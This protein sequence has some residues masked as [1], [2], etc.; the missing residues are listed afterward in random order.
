LPER[1]RQ[2]LQNAAVERFLPKYE[3]LIEAYYRRLAEDDSPL[4]PRATR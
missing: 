3:D 1:I 4:T 2:Q